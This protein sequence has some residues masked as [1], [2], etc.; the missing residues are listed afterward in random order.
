[1]SIYYKHDASYNT[2]TPRNLK[3]VPPANPPDGNQ[4]E[5]VV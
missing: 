4:Q 5:E 3:V 1:M 2:E